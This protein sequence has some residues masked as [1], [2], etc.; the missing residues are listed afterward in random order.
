MQGGG[1]QGGEG[2]G[3]QQHLQFEEQELERA[4]VDAVLQG[5]V[6]LDRVGHPVTFPYVLPSTKHV[7]ASPV[8]MRYLYDLS[9]LERAFPG[10]FDGMRILEIGGGYGGFAVTVCAVH[11][12]AACP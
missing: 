9:L 2:V 3:G 11:R 1:V 4:H 8:L 12:P 5:A 7:R 6:E 10:G